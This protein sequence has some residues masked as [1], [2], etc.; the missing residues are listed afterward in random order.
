MLHLPKITQL[1]NGRA[2]IHCQVLVT[3]ASSS[4][5]YIAHSATFLPS[6]RAHY[7]FL[8]PCQSL[9]GPVTPLLV[10]PHPKAIDKADPISG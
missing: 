4:F 5:F 8:A 2:K 1:I 7:P 9:L 10:P 6:V 3:P